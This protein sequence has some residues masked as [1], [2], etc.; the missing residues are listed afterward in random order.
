M[1]SQTASVGPPALHRPS[2]HAHPKGV[3]CCTRTASPCPAKTHAGRRGEANKKMC[4]KE[5]NW[6]QADDEPQTL[7]ISTFSGAFQIRRKSSIKENL[8][9]MTRQDLLK[10]IR[11]RP[12]QKLAALICFALQEILKLTAHYS[13]S[14][15]NCQKRVT[16]HSDQILPS[17]RELQ[18]VC[19]VQRE[20]AQRSNTAH[21][22]IPPRGHTRLIFPFMNF[23][24]FEKDLA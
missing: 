12:F 24:C 6:H 11:N 8:L 23:D 18:K 1:K 16:N 22:T 20:T 3:G 5:K 4:R 10:L 7:P 14:F 19:R 15:L 21:K 13:I 17:H 9:C 2:A